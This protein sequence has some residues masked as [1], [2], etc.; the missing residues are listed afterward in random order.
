[1]RRVG[2]SAAARCV[3]L[4]LASFSSLRVHPSTPPLCL[5]PQNRSWYSGWEHIPFLLTHAVVLYY[6]VT[7]IGQPYREALLKAENE[8]LR[9]CVCSLDLHHSAFCRRR[10]TLPTVS[11]SPPPGTTMTWP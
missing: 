6:I 4:S 10:L 3:L 7:S 2:R 9:L 8:G 11:L 5:R 1:M